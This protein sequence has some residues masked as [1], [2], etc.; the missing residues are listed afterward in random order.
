MAQPNAGFDWSKLLGPGLIVAVAGLFMTALRPLLSWFLTSRV[1]GSDGELG[2]FSELMMK[3]MQTKAGRASMRE[4]MD[5]LYAD[6]IKKV[7]DAI[8]VAYANRDTLN[9]VNLSITALSID[10]SKLRES[11]AEIPRLTD[12][13]SDM[14][15]SME[16]ISEHMQ[17]TREFM[18]RADEREKERDRLARIYA[19]TGNRRTHDDPESPRRRATDENE[20]RR[21]N[22]GHER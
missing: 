6:R 2:R 16:E 12:A 18:A 1:F 22:G 20:P 4:Y 3:A 15:G 14:A 9:Q 10:Q 17:I 11:T 5:D 21:L 8:N 19:E 7:D 13:I